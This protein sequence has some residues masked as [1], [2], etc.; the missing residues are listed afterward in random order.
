MADKLD[1]TSEITKIRTTGG[2]GMDEGRA[3]RLLEEY[4]SGGYVTP[5]A[6][7]P[8]NVDEAIKRI[9]DT[10]AKTP[11]DRRSK[12]LKILLLRYV[13]KYRSNPRKYIV[14]PKQIKN[15]PS[16]FE[17]A[18]AAFTPNE[19]SEDTKK[20][21]RDF[22]QNLIAWRDEQVGTPDIE[23]MKRQYGLAPSPYNPEGLTP[24]DAENIVSGKPL[25]AIDI[26]GLRQGMMSPSMISEGDMRLSGPAMISTPGADVEEE[27]Y[28]LPIR[29]IG[30]E[31]VTGETERAETVP[32]TE[33]EGAP[34]EEGEM[35]LV[36]PI[37]TTP[38]VVIAPPP[39]TPPV[40]YR[41]EVSLSRKIVGGGVRAPSMGS[42]GDLAKRLSS[43]ISGRV[44][45]AGVTSAVVKRKTSQMKARRVKSIYNVTSSKMVFGKK[46][47][48]LTV[49]K[50]YNPLKKVPI[51]GTITKLRDI[52][53]AA[54]VRVGGRTIAL[55]S[56][57]IDGSVN[58]LKLKGTIGYVTG[59]VDS[60]KKMIPKPQK[61][62]TRKKG[63]PIIREAGMLGGIVNSAVGSMKSD[64]VFPKMD[65]KV[66]DMSPVAFNF[67]LVKKKKKQLPDTDIVEEYVEHVYE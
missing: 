14:H 67:G 31:E 24:S 19:M 46:Q 6:L 4:E 3:K 32:E 54:S 63:E 56:K 60:V 61:V 49:G 66:P 2:V 57:S 38:P 33:E 1:V 21:V 65:F 58:P 15:Q 44:T 55:L 42:T 43:M 45:A 27:V 30:I 50:M 25:E 34:P 20:Q 12:W 22:F 7:Q 9:S 36:A 29:G 47:P 10:K 53:P 28:K 64:I 40:R 35:T 17:D 41:D 18:L 8:I 13:K 51:R 11:A 37:T 16:W 52:K 5:E 39:A 62:I 23:E 26:E 59:A 48:I